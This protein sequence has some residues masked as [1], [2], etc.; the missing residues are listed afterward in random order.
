MLRKWLFGY[1]PSATKLPDA[2]YLTGDVRMRMLLNDQIITFKCGPGVVIPIKAL[3]VDL[4][5]VEY[6]PE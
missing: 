6:V 1:K 2:W 4:P 3:P 5:Y